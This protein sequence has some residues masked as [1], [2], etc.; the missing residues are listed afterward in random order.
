MQLNNMILKSAIISKNTLWKDA[1]F[2][3]VLFAPA[4]GWL[5]FGDGTRDI[6]IGEDDDAVEFTASIF[7]VQEDLAHFYHTAEPIK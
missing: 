1:E 4:R 6:E 3:S 2:K 5:S 7:P